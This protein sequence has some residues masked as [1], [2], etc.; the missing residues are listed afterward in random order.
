MPHTGIALESATLAAKVFQGCCDVPILN[1][2]KPAASL[3]VLI[4]E[5]AKVC[6]IYELSLEAEAT[7]S[8]MTFTLQTSADRKEAARDL[9]ARSAEV[10]DL[11][12]DHLLQT[13]LTKITSDLERDALRL[14]ECEL[15]CVHLNLRR[16]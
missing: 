14:N 2:L 3:C 4:C 6:N 13:S 8:A 15:I 7:S 1:F 16:H 11:I 12:V 9:S 5:T 10:M